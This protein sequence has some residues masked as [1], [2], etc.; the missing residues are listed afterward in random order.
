MFER[1]T[2]AIITRLTPEYVT[3]VDGLGAKGPLIIGSKSMGCCV[4]SKS[5]TSFSLPVG[6]FK[7]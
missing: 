3:A 1:N 5:P 7:S 2:T 4:A 6:S